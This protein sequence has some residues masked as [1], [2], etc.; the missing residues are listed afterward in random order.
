MPRY[1]RAH[2][3]LH[4]YRGGHGLLGGSIKLAGKDSELAT[5]LSDLSGS[6]SSGLEIQPYLTCYPLPGGEFHAV[7]RTWPDREAPRAGCV[8]THTILIPREAWV[9]F[10]NVRILN[11]CFRNIRTSPSYSFTD[12][13]E[14][15]ISGETD[16]ASG[17]MK[18]GH[19]AARTFVARYFGQ[20]VR[21]IVWLNAENPDEYF[22][23]LVEHLWPRLRSA[24]SCC[25]FSLQ[26]RQLQDRP[27]DLLFAPG[28]VYSRFNK[29]TPEQLLDEGKTWKAT[30][31]ETEPWCK[32]WAD[33]FF[34]K[35]K[36]LPSGENELPIWNELGEEPGDLRK[37][38]LIQELRLRAG[39]SPTA[40]VG[41]IDVVESVARDARAGLPLKLSVIN[42]AIESAVAATDVKEGLIALRLIDDRMRREA[43]REVSPRFQSAIG[44]AAELLAGRE[45]LRAI[46]TAESQSASS[47]ESEEFQNGILSGLCEAAQHDSSV[48]R[49]VEQYPL[50]AIRMLNLRPSLAAVYLQSAGPS[51]PDQVA[52]WL[53]STKDVAVLRAVRKATLPILKGTES[54]EIVS[55]L[56]R[57][58]ASAETS[59]TLDQIVKVSAIFKNGPFLKVAMDR[60]GSVYPAEVRRWGLQERMPVTDETAALLAS[61]FNDSRTGFEEFLSESRLKGEQQA[62]VLAK[63]LELHAPSGM[64]FWLRELISENSAYVGILISVKRPAPSLID[65][66]LGMVLEEVENVRLPE[67]IRVGIREFEGSPIFPLVVDKIL[68]ATV[69]DELTGK[70]AGLRDDMMGNR[71]LS[72]RWLCTIPSG[73]LTALISQ[74]AAGGQEGLKRAWLW[75]AEADDPLY[76]RRDSAIS[77]VAEALLAHTRSFCDEEIGEA[78]A[79]VLKRARRESD[80]DTFQKLASKCLRFSF[81][82]T[83]LILGAV[84]A[85]SYPDVYAVVASDRRQPSFFSFFFWSY[86]WDKGKDLR[87]ALIDAFMNS[88]WNPAYLALAAQRAG[89]LRKIFKRVRRRTRGDDYIASMIRDVKGR[90]SSPE[91]IAVRGVLESLNSDPDFYEEWD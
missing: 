40:G 65:R 69:V 56:L 42:S 1:I 15:D 20:G 18:F 63:M 50:T 83:Q 68:R 21:P 87:V 25:T 17:E 54:E 81:D 67:S 11:V 80:S 58:L 30:D 9:L 74:G 48:M 75:I 26:P 82:N 51:A 64:P 44:R 28:A 34:S 55:A 38:T 91:W 36:D 19:D 49:A 84:V 14:I 3:L 10:R 35:G 77:D 43:F 6:L 31:G 37:L 71:E 78:I 86:G 66:A 61:T 12:P 7:A 46:E 22:W 88:T 4:G 53:A 79:S 8:L 16:A 23:R 45:P 73:H 52:S 39:G 70:T 32:F 60:I 62:L 27:F 85:E 47:R 33:A 5:R 90:S 59:W 76:K 13:V 72:E 89:I 24:F 29:F 57:D 41:A 2:Q